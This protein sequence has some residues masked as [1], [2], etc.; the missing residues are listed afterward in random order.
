MNSSFFKK[1]KTGKRFFLFCLYG[2]GFAASWTAFAVFCHV[3]TIAEVPDILKP[4]IGEVSCWF[5]SEYFSLFLNEKGGTQ[6]PS[7]LAIPV[8]QT[9]DFVPFHHPA[10]LRNTFRK[11]ISLVLESLNDFLSVA[12]LLSYLMDDLWY[13]YCVVY[14]FGERKNSRMSMRNINFFSILIEITIN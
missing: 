4:D 12:A 14:H 5:S 8:S 13:T 6:P 3:T 9:F 7:S 10:T 2:W 1:A 11:I